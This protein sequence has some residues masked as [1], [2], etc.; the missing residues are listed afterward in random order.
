MVY[1]RRKLQQE[2]FRETVGKK[3]QCSGIES[4][5]HGHQQRKAEQ[6]GPSLPSEGFT[7]R[8]G[9][10]R[11]VRNGIDTVDTALSEELDKIKFSSSIF[12]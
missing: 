5:T 3:C 9:K 12:L 8:E 7:N 10:E 2:V 6:V 1:R 4:Q 11:S